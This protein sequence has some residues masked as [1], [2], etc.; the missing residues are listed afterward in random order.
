MLAEDRDI[1]LH[2]WCEVYSWKC[3]DGLLANF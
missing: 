2:L 1:E 3:R